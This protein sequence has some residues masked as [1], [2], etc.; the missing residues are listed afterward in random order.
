MGYI[1]K[2]AKKLYSL[3]TSAPLAGVLVASLALGGCA[4]L[5]PKS[6]VTSKVD[7]GLE[8]VLPAYNGKKARVAVFDFDWNTG[9]SKTTIGIGGTEFSFSRQ[10]QSAYAEGLKD[11]LNTAL[12]QS[13][14]YQV[15]ERQN[16]DAIKTEIG[17]QE[18]G[19][20]DST[21]VQR[22]NVK[23]ADLVIKAAITGWA[24]GSSGSSGSIAGIFGK[25]AK[26]V[27]GAVS[28]GYRKSSLAMTIRIF[29]AKNSINLA[30]TTVETEATDINYGAALGAFT[31][32]SGMS[33][34]L[35]AYSKTPMEKAI[36]SAILDATKYIVENTPNDYMV[37]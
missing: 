24:P 3:R 20:T 28:G 1:T 8:D 32:G 33:G 5:E 15:L 34:G 19:Y 10:E 16:F 22:G 25:T 4:A 6:T 7:R 29:D 31:G 11:M 26:A 18:D 13:K 30:A 37:H 36:R 35:G 23:G 17:I 27:A 9:G 2:Q 14:R 12:I 21:G